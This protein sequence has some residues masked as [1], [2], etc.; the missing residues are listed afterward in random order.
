M[1]NRLLKPI[2]RA[3][4][5]ALIRRAQKGD[6]V[7]LDAIYRR[8]TGFVRRIACEYIY[9]SLDV[10]DLCQCGFVGLGI[11]LRKFDTTKGYKFISYAVWWIRRQIRIAVIDQDNTI[12]RPIHASLLTARFLNAHK[13]LEQDIG[14]TVRIE[15]AM[16]LLKLTERDR[17]I[18][19]AAL[20]LTVS[21]DAAINASP[22][23]RHYIDS[24]FG[25]DGSVADTAVDAI[26]AKKAVSSLLD[27]LNKREKDIITQRY[28][29][30]GGGPQTLES[31]AICF[32]LTRQRVRQIETVAM[33]K[34]RRERCESD[35]L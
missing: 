27:S 26:D 35:Y 20:R 33:Q 7:A 9:T 10:E 3:E 25:E 28:G 24:V 16:E 34:L 2:P 30:D 31:I 18:L 22:M 21:L 32:G 11:A 19:R 1:S 6:A 8:N 5:P 14:H 4:E 29:L 13:T 12:H 15:E 23:P 17:S